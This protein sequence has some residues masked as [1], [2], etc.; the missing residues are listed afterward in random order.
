LS[1]AAPK[2]LWDFLCLS[3]GAQN[4]FP[5]F[6]QA[7]VGSTLYLVGQKYSPLVII[8]AMHLPTS[9]CKKHKNLRAN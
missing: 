5:V 8:N 3:H 2:H 1:L 4:S 6:Q 9:P 7:F